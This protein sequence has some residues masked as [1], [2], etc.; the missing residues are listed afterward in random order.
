MVEKELDSYV[1]QYNG[2]TEKNPMKYVQYEYGKKSYRVEY[3]N[4]V[5][6]TKC[7]DDA[8]EKA[9]NIIVLEFPNGIQKFHT[10]KY[11]FFAYK[12]RKF[13]AYCCNGMC[14]LIYDMY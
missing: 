14:I 3:N 10:D 13:I 1:K 9:L 4:N 7:I 8:C 12:N 11:Q 6:R 5:T 2:F